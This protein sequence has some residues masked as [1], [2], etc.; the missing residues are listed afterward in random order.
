[1]LLFNP[2]NGRP[3]YPMMRPHLGMRPPFSPNGHSGAP[4]L[5]EMGDTAPAGVTATHLDPYAGRPDAIC[6][7]TQ[8]SGAPTVLRRF[9]V[10]AVEHSVLVSPN[11]PDPAGMR[12]RAGP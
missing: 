11:R 7:G 10:V 1:V 12:L 8:A 3:A 4:Y 9:N 2:D 5:G 6:P